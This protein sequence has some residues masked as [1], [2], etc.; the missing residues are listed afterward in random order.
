MRGRRS[1]TRKT[2]AHLPV[3]LRLSKELIER[4]TR[5]GGSIRADASHPRSLA[6][7]VGEMKTLG[8]STLDREVQ[9]GIA[10]DQDSVVELGTNRR[11]FENLQTASGDFAAHRQVTSALPVDRRPRSVTTG[12][13]PSESASSLYIGSHDQAAATG[14]DTYFYQRCASTTAAAFL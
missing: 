10:T 5:L 12:T 1:R 6:I 3:W 14:A 2:F 11:L 8:L 13:I 9:V 4:S 7:S